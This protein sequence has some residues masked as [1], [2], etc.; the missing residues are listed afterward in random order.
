MP[1]RIHFDQWELGIDLRKDES[2]SDANRLVDCLNAYVTTGWAIKPRPGLTEVG[3][4]TSGTVGL[5]AFNG[6]LQ[7]FSDS[8]VTHEHLS[9]GTPVND[10]EVPNASYDIISDDFTA[11]NG[12]SLGSGCSITVGVMDW[13]GSQTG[14]SESYRNC[15]LKNGVSYAVSFDTVGRTAGSITVYLGD[16]AGSTVSTNTTTTETITMDGDTGRIRFVADS[17][18]DGNIDNLTIGSVGSEVYNDSFNSSPNGWTFEG[19]FDIAGGELRMNGSNT[20]GDRAYKDISLVNGSSYEIEFTVESYVSGGVYVQL[21]T[22]TGTTRTANGTYVETIAMDEADGLIEIVASANNSDL[23]LSNIIVRESTGVGNIESIPF[24]DVFN[25]AIYV[26]VKYDNNDVKH[27]YLS[28]DKDATTGYIITDE[29]CPHS[30]A[31]LISASS[32][33]S[34]DYDVV[35]YC[36]TDD[37]TDWTTASDAGF[38]PT[39]TRAPGS[40]QAVALG[41]FQGQLV[42]F[43]VDAIQLWNI[44]PDPSTISIDRIIGNVG[45][46]FPRSVQAVAGDLYFLTDVGYRSIAYQ[47]YTENVEDVDI[48]TP[49]DDLVRPDIPAASEGISEAPHGVFY[50]GGGQYWGFLDDQVYVYTFSRTSKIAAWTRYEL[51]V[52]VDYAANLGNTLYLRSGDTVYKLDTTATDDDG[53]D[54]TVE[55]KMAFQSFQKPG[56][57]KQIFGFDAVVEGSADI[58]HRH[59]PN[60]PTVETDAI[61]VSGDTR[62][63]MIYPVNLVTTEIA[64]VIRNSSGTLERFNAISYLYNLIG[65]F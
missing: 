61:T 11:N 21:G 18:W 3:T 55:V 15:H 2:I 25:G 58:S 12:W 62:V 52:T 44:D 30:K 20:A 60:N 34:T 35:R 17:S 46:R 43:A 65:G 22:N 47:K 7:T 16:Q 41:D 40:E 13:D 6:K 1:T 64:P 23:E 24:A 49:I 42:V 36:A 63:G 51:P 33:W 5:M 29:N 50:S 45:S 28:G 31:N 4:L 48:G 54:F 19:D 10:N 57:N 32:V 56:V 9:D 37:P 39:G 53:T 8:E 59:D 27:H 38:L 26:A 14:E